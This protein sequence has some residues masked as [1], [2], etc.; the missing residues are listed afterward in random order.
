MAAGLTWVNGDFILDASG[1]VPV[2]TSTNK[3]TRDL[4][5]MLVTSTEFGGNET[6]YTRYNP[7]YGTELNNLALYRGLS[8]SAIRDVVLMKLNEAIAGYI[9]LQESRANL[10][11]GEIITYVTTDAVF[12]ATQMN[13]ILITVK[14][15]TAISSEISLGTFSQTTV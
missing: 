7:N 2:V 1:T 4:G 8:R 14:F 15:G 5:K 6:S 9:I 11:I 10:E 3:C 12:D 13:K